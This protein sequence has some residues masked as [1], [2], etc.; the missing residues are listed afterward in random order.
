MILSKKEVFPLT[1]IIVCFVVGFYL[2]PQLPEQVPSHWN[3][4]GEI[5][6]WAGKNF[7]VLFFPSLT[8]VIYL[9]M[10]F[11]P[12]IDP[13]RRN[14]HK[15][16]IPYFFFR[17]TLVLFFCLLY[18]YTLY[19]GLGFNINI[20]YFIIPAISLL[21]IIIGAFL[22]K[23]KKNYFV[24]IRTPWTI[25]SEEV[26]DKTHKVAGKLYILAGLISLVGLLFINQAIFIFI[27]AII[28]AALISVIYSYLV[29]RKIGGFKNE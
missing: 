27:T 21:F 3:A 2:Y 17:L 25:H 20:N 28:L 23:I 26:W 5:D 22:P 24:G 16:A 14:Y 8:L 13:L 29:F 4:Q 6:D 1:I 12:L 15:F 9:L 10:T 19:S 18:L 11:I 7:T